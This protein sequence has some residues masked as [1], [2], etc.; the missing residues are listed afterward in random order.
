M[1]L[2]SLRKDKFV[3]LGHLGR[4]KIHQFTILWFSMSTNYISRPCQTHFFL[5][6][7]LF[8][9]CSSER[10]IKYLLQPAHILHAMSKLL[11]K[12]KN[13]TSLIILYFQQL[14]SQFKVSLV[15]PFDFLW[16]IKSEVWWIAVSC[17]QML[18]PFFAGLEF[19]STSFNQAL[20]L[21]SHITLDILTTVELF[22]VV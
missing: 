4:R 8:L 22:P 14:N 3:T 16:F 19:Q 12:K 7:N 2:L 21:K 10:S 11:S 1:W 15:T 17:D 5:L 9:F 6:R 20:I 18:F 13:G